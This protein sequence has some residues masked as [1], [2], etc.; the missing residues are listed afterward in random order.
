MKILVTG[1]GGFI[2]CNLC[3]KLLEDG[4][5][6]VA[7]YRS[8]APPFLRALGPEQARR[9]TLSQGD[10]TDREYVLSL[11]DEG[12]AGILNSAIMTSPAAREEEY[13]AA[14]ARTNIAG[15]VNML[16]LALRANVPNYVYVSSFSVYGRAFGLGERIPEEGPF[17]L[18]GTYAVTKRAC[19]LLTERYGALA[20]AK[21][22][23]AR[24]ATPYGPYERATNSRTA[25]GAVCGMVESAAAGRSVT[26]TGPEIERDWTYV[27][28]TVEALCLLLTAKPGTLR[29]TEYNVS[30][31]RGYSNAE[32]AATLRSICPSFE[33]SFVDNP[34][35]A[36]ISVSPPCQRGIADITR[37]T[38]DTGFLPRFDLAA[39]LEKYLDHVR[40]TPAV[41]SF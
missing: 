17:Q 5:E 19:E 4:H 18:G 16:E 31:A 36:D 25:L 21:A 11:A 40:N 7:S 39:G 38:E 9:V 37:L 27:E 15:T 1:S 34:A 41:D 24:I 12:V 35:E 23:S 30:C 2:G 10:L 20:G 14:M 26:I 3:L 6:V 32:V 8:A 33:Y 13:F 22:V 29:H 28:D